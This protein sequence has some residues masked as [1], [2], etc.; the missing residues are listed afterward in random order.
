MSVP[1]ILK[2]FAGFF[3][4]VLMLP[5]YANSREKLPDADSFF[6]GLESVRSLSCRF[7]QEQFIKGL[8]R[9]IRLRGSFYMTKEGDLAWIVKEPVR[10]YCIIRKDKLATW[11]AESDSRREIDLKDHPAFSL[12]IKMMKDFFAGK[13][14]VTG[15]YRC[16]VV[17]AEKILL[18][19]LKH[20]P[21]SG[22]VEKIE[23]SLSAGRRSISSI[24]ITSGSGDRNRMSFGNIVLDAPIPGSVWKKGAEK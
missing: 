11:D 6:K 15:G 9:P 24:M 4:L 21:L 2:I 1:G 8:R 20:N 17:S 7:Q 22:N 14:R 12:M 10:F 13:I 16:T 3:F 23:M 5:S 19:P 18:H